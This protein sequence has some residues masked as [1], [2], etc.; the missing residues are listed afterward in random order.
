VQWSKLFQVMEQLVSVLPQS[1]M[2]DRLRTSVM[3]E[4]LALM[5]KQSG[6]TVNLAANARNFDR[7]LAAN[8][9][10]YGQSPR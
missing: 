7:R 10:A 3:K 1:A 5:T 9:A 4:A 6:H 8:C 2:V